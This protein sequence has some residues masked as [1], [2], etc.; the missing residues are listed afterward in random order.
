[1]SDIQVLYEA[2]PN[3]DSMKF[4]VTK[5][6]TDETASFTEPAL[7]ARSP[8]ASKIFGFPWS[9]GVMIGP[10]FVT[11]TKQDWVD[12]DILADPLS[13][14]I[15]EH[16]ENNEAVLLAA[17][18]SNFESDISEDDSE[19]VKQIKTILNREVRPMVALDGG[20]ITFSEFKDGVVYVNM[21]GACSG[22]PSSTM[23]L[24]QGVEARLKMK[25][26]EVNEVVSL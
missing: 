6:I 2:T 22:C 1:M 23:T 19:I 16:I 11:V 18:E 13:Q 25:I 5:Q 17:P 24:K 3:P 20:D 4:V 14:L 10:N 8:L 21:Q 12:W 7:A 26:P 15:Q 9:A